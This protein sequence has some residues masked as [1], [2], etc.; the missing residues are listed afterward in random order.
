M[1]EPLR[2]RTE[3]ASRMPISEPLERFWRVCGGTAGLPSPGRGSCL[4]FTFFA[5]DAHLT[6]WLSAS[7][8]SSLFNLL[9]SG[10]SYFSAV[11]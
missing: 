1:G 4:R 9:F 2:I 7:F 8:S 3:D 10:M 5:I 11:L 6:I